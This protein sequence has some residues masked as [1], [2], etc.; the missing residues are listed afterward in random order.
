[1][2]ANDTQKAWKIAE[3]IGV[4]FLCTGDSQYPMAAMVRKEEEAIYFLTDARSE[5]IA[6]I[7]N[8][9]SVQLSFSD[10]SSNE[11]LFM[12]GDAKVSDDRDKIADLWTTAAKAYWDSANDPAIRLVT[13][14]PTRAEFWDGPNK[15]VAV[16]KMLFAAATGGRPDMGDNRKTSM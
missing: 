9:K 1:M 13:F 12:E 3:S 10:K 14:Y 4:C 16:S 2:A 8:G 15:I 5:K 7:S 6:E 11:F